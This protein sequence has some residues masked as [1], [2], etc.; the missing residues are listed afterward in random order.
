MILIVFT[1]IKK[2]TLSLSIDTK[3]FVLYLAILVSCI[4]TIAMLHTV[5]HLISATI[6]L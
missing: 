5:T 6:S 4:H 3:I 2:G 1:I